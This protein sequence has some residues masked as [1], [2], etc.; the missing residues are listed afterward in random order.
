MAEAAPPRRLDAGGATIVVTGAAG[1]VGTHLCAHLAER[2][3]S[4]TIR[5]A[6]REPGNDLRLDLGEGA[7]AGETIVAAR[8]D[9]IVHLA[10]EASVAGADRAAAETWRVNLGGTLAIADAL[11][12][13][14]SDATMLFV[15]S[16]EIYGTAFL[17]GPVTERTPPQPAS[18][19]AQTKYATEQ[20]LAGVLPPSMTLIAARPSNHIGPGQSARFAIPSFADQIAAGERRGAVAIDV[21]NLETGRDFLDVRDVVLAY[22]DLLARFHGSGARKTFNIASGRTRTIRSILDLLIREATVPCTVRVDPD[23]VRPAEIPSADVS[24]AALYEATGW[25]PD[26]AIERTVTDVM[27]DARRRRDSVAPD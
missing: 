25:Q 5:T 12:R 11:A 21:G 15:S 6:G 22:G 24:A 27:G 7:A 13:A 9:A 18:V 3:P 2:F 20:M 1:F 4:A 19:Y 16:A 23:R 8:P 17:D 10:G 14:G 26:I